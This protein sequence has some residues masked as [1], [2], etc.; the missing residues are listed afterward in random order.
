MIIGCGAG[1]STAAQFARKRDRKAKIIILEKGKYPQYSKCGLPY[2]L[3]GIVSSS[4]DLIEFS[5]EWFSKNNIDL[6]LDTNVEKINPNKHIIY[7]KKDRNI[8]G[9]FCICLERLIVTFL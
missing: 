8:I 1:G 5:Q 4:N 9:F 6:F 3:S 7:A 2:V